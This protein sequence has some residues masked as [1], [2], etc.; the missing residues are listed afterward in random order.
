[1]PLAMTAH[2]VYAALDPRRCATI[3]RRVIRDVVRGS[4]GF[5]GLLISDD[6]SMRA[7]NGDLASRARAALAAGCDIALHCNGDLEEMRAVAA[8]CRRLTGRAAARAAAALAR[9]PRV[10]EPLDRPAAVARFDAALAGWSGTA[11]GAR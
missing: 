6:L 8:G 3:S 5:R 9:K 4:I 11:R 1:M 10:V 7:L 2:V